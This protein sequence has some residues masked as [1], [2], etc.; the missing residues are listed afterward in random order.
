[1]TVNAPRMFVVV[2]S[3]ALGLVCSCGRLPLRVE[4]QGAE[5]SFSAAYVT[6]TTGSSVT[7]RLS[8][9]RSGCNPVRGWGERT[10][11][12]TLT[13]ALI[14]HRKEERAA[15][16]NAQWVVASDDEWVIA[17][18]YF[19]VRNGGDVYRSLKMPLGV[20]SVP[21]DVGRKGGPLTLHARSRDIT[22][23]DP[24]RDPELVVEGAAAAT[25]CPPPDVGQPRDTDLPPLPITALIGGRALVLRGA[26]LV[27]VGADETLELSDGPAY[28]KNGAGF[29]KSEDLQINFRSFDIGLKRRSMIHLI[30]RRVPAGPLLEINDDAV[31]IGEPDASGHVRV[32]VDVRTPDFPLT[33]RGEL[34]VLRCSK[35]E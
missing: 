34:P 28:C 7:V 18:A 13:P 29:S 17:E 10:L 26:V 1:M 15:S 12:L 11:D 3:T 14:H 19:R 16:L 30:G 31:R 4:I 8:S 24:D 20:A 23:A 25:P 21:P 22:R 6:P 33:I 35:R 5:E 32:T 2:A 27:G 9:R